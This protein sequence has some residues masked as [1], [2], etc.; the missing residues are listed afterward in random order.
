[1]RER[2]VIAFVGL[3]LA[4]IGLYGVP[5][6]YFLADLVRSQERSALAGTATALQELY[7]EHTSHGGRID[8]RLLAVGLVSADRVELA[9]P[10]GEPV[11]VGT[12]P[13]GEGGIMVRRELSDGSVLRLSVSSDTV[14]A[15]IRDALMPLVLL[16]M[17]LGLGSAIL[18]V[19][20]ARRLSRP[21]QELAGF[22]QDL[23]HG[24]FDLP[25]PT[26]SIPE[27]D[28]IGSSLRGAATRLDELVTRERQFAANASHQLRTPI[29]ALRLSLEDLTLWPETDPA[30]A[31]EL[32]R[33]LGELDRLASAIDE[34]LDLARGRRLDAQQEIDL[35][36]LVKASAS[37]WPRRLAE[38]SRTLT[39]RTGRA[40]VT[41]VPAGP[42]E[43]VL[44]V[45]IDNARL[46][47]E[48]TITVE[49]RDAGTHL[50]IA[51]A[52]EGTRRP[53]PDVFRRGVSTGDG[54]SA[55]IGLAVASELAEVCGG[56]L[57]LDT[58]AP[59]TRFVLWLPHGE[60]PVAQP[61]S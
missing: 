56:H 36:R 24:R 8:E 60:R 13:D 10:G 23:G 42:I 49:V 38:E 43:Q 35:V 30:V 18:G 32:E 29:T 51:V 39:L 48:G 9:P 5:R 57:S 33:G 55:G 20:L 61:T 26:Y 37:R 50:E 7:D 44:D 54:S 40:A 19:V 17:G 45:L 47:G 16:G 3:T 46:H 21:F 6:A 58:T 52:D 14:G 25:V 31:T 12:A 53:G 15:T 59:S 22:S 28:A 4:V 41:R 27:A 11:A 1:M 2:L 34:L